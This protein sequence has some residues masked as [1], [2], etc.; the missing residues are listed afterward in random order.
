MVHRR[1]GPPIFFAA[2]AAGCRTI[3]VLTGYGRPTSRH[4]A[5]DFI[6]RDIV[7]A[8]EIVLARKHRE[9]RGDNSRALGLDAGFRA[10]RFSRS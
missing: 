7:E 4:A 8:A 5:R 2:K 9:G 3:F 10:N 1:Q 6:A